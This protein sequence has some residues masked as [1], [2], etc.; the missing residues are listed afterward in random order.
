MHAEGYQIRESREW[1]R[2]RFLASSNF[3]AQG[4][5]VKPTDLFRLETDADEEDSEPK[6]PMTHEQVASAI[7]RFESI[8]NW[9][10]YGL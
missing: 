6:E 7:E 8:T 4:T 10:T 5:S 2:V 1:A 9:Q 3:N